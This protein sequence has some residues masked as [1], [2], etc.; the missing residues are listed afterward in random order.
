MKDKTPPNRPVIKFADIK[1]EL[2]E[3][4][5]EKLKELSIGEQVSLI[6]G[7][8]TLYVQQEIARNRISL[9]GSP[10]PMVGLVG[11]KSGRIYTFALKALLPN[12]DL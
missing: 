1:T 2:Q 5:E 12:I 10:I 11:I 3:K 8:I 9:G 6:D 4:L 7:F